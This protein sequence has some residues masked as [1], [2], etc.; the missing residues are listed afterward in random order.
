MWFT[1]Q[2]SKKNSDLSHWA[3][4]KQWSIATQIQ[5]L[6]EF[7]KGENSAEQL[8]YLSLEIE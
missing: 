2:G 8:W 7:D 4:I 5:T 6:S 3:E 1:G